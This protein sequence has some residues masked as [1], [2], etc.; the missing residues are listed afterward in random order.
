MTM[1]IEYRG[2]RPDTEKASYIAANA[3]IIG[4]V[5][6]EEGSSVWFG[7]VLRG[8]SGPIRVGKNSNIQDNCVL[9]CD[10]GGKLEIGE[11]VTVG[12]GAIVHGCTIG[13]GCMIGMGAILLN[14][15]VIGDHC[16]VGAGALVTSGKEYPPHSLIIGSPAKVVKTVT[17]AHLDMMEHGAKEYC[18]FS[19]SYPGPE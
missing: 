19:R 4:D 10:E 9:H 17:D 14:D 5:K 15:A 16:L 6:L 3:S 12:H 8:D 1:I 18:A 11:Q 13:D 7:A 2:H